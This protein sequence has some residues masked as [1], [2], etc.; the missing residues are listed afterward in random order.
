[1]AAGVAASAGDRLTGRHTRVCSPAKSDSG[2]A[3]TPSS[4]CYCARPPF[5]LERLQQR[6]A[7]YL[8]Y[9]ALLG[10]FTP[11]MANISRPI[12]PC[13]G[14][15]TVTVYSRTASG[16]TA[17]IRTL[18]GALTGLSQPEWPAVTTGAAPPPPS[19]T[20]VPTLSEWTLIL[21]AGIVCLW[22]AMVLRRRS[23]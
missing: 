8:L 9:A 5:A 1:M 13:G 7:V 6:D 11:S 15:P 20:A 12:K 10:S 23:S 4:M 21:L 3:R 22:G 2:T 19:T 18:S 14:G 16:N 17:P